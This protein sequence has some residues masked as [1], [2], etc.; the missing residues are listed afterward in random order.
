MGKYKKGA[1]LKYARLSVTGGEDGKRV[2]AGNQTEKPEPGDPDV[3]LPDGGS[4]PL[5]NVRIG[6]LFVL[7]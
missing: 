3:A 4:E 2:Q 7:G 5:D 1:M 6:E